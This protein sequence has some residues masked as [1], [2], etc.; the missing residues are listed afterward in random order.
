MGVACLTGHR[1]G[2]SWGVESWTWVR[3]V[4]RSREEGR[5]GESGTGGRERTERKRKRNRKAELERHT[6]AERKGG[7]TTTTQRE[8]RRLA[9]G[10]GEGSMGP[11]KE[12]DRQ[13]FR[14]TEMDT[15]REM[16]TET[17]AALL[18][19]GRW[20]EGGRRN[21]EL[22]TEEKGKQQER[23]EAGHEE[24]GRKLSRR[25]RVE[26]REQLGIPGGLC[27]DLG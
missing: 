21:L 5:G 25:P 26:K 24:G 11:G 20:G 17:L 23:A 3:S 12:R 13:T 22:E 15:Y 6:H 19:A 16:E 1:A 9:R 10:E 27:L 8:P 14:I 7:E 18:R 4:V 2:Q